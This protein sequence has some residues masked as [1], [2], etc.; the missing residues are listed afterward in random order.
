MKIEVRKAVVEDCERALELIQELAVYEKEADAV[1][2]SLQQ[3]SSDGFGEDPA[4]HLLVGEIDGSI[5]GIALYYEKYSTWK[6]RALYLED[7]IVSEASRGNGL[8]LALFKAVIKEAYRRGS[9]RMEW[10]VLDWNQTAIDFYKKMG[11]SIEDEWLNGRFS[12]EK[13]KAICENEGI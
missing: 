9:G 3:F 1:D 11:A 7:L 10:Q 12:K 4:Y 6:G 5:E 8:G 2:L 13:I